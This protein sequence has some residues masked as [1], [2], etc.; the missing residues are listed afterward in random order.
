MAVLTLIFRRLGIP[1]A[2]HKTVGPTTVL[3]YLGIELDTVRMQARL[4][5]DK[6][7]R[8]HEL[9][10]TFLSRKSCTKRELLS[11]LGHLNFACRVV[12]PGRTFISRL[13]ELSKGVKKLHHH[14]SISSESRKDL[15]MWQYFL[16]GWNG[17]SMFLDAHPTSASDMQLYTDASG[18]GHGGYFRGRWFQERWSPSLKLETDPSL[19][20]AFQELYPI[21]VAS[22]LWGHLWVRKRILFYCDNLA[23]VHIINK[24]RSKSP[25][26]MKL[27]RRLVITAASS[28]FMFQ[29][30]HIP[31]KINHIADALSRFQVRRFR[32]AAP[33]AEPTQCQI[34]SVVMFS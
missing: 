33:T 7:S 20:I 21:V 12:I 9:L 6:L 26:I 1:I 31:G 32:E 3:E 10:K 30:E 4:P 15:H 16:S 29:A 5:Q 13:I 28:N 23:T 2:P 18:I 24:G 25:A 17:V 11:L 34:P 27:M 19:S 8:I 14:I 22:I